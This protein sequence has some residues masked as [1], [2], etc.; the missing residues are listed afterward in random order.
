MDERL[1]KIL[2]MVEK[3][4]RYTG[5]ETNS[6][7]KDLNKVSLKVALAFPDIY[8]IGISNLG[9]QILYHVLNS[10]DD[11]A[12]ER[13]YSVWGDMEEKM[14]QEGI[15][16]CSLESALPLSDFDIIGV[17]LQHELAYT[18]MLNMLDLGGVPL[19]ASERGDND[20]L[21]LA[22]G[23]SSF[24]PET[25]S[26]FIDAF[27]IG[28]GEDGL[29]EI[30]DT[31]IKWKEKGPEKGTG[32]RDLLLDLSKIKG[33]YIPSLFSF[34]FADTG[35]I[36]KINSIEKEYKGVER[37]LVP[38]L[39]SAP[40]PTSFIVPNVRP[41]HDR[42]SLEVA[43]GCSRFCHF[44]QA[45]Y[46][47][48]PV[49]ERS[50]EKIREIGE[51]AL[52]ETGFDEAALLS[53]STGD[54][55]CL[56]GLLPDL[57]SRYK[58]KNVNLSFPS[59]RVDTITP[60]IMG[61][62]KKMRANSFTI[63]PEAGTQRMRDLI[64]KGV[65]EEQILDTVTEMSKAG[66]KSVKLYFMIGLPTETMEDL[67]GIIDLSRAILKTGRSTGTM[68]QVT[69][70]I[71]AFVP[72]AHTPFQ[73]AEQDSAEKTAEKH[74]YLRSTLRDRGISLKWQDP[75]M[76]VLEGA[77]SRG[78][79]RVGKAILGAFKKGCRFDSWNDQL[80]RSH[81]EEAFAE[82]GIEMSDYL[83]RRAHDETL[84]WDLVNTGVDKSFLFD[85]LKRSDLGA[86]TE[87]CRYGKCS[88]CGVC[89]HKTVKINLFKGDVLSPLAEPKVATSPLKTR[90]RVNYSKEGPARFLGH[91]DCMEGLVRALRRSG[92]PLIYSSG[93]HPSPKIS[94]GSPIPLGTESNAEYF[95]IEIEGNIS[96]EDFMES[97]RAKAPAICAIKDAFVIP[98]KSLSITNSV[99]TEVYI[100]KAD[101]TLIPAETMDEVLAKFIEAKE[102]IIVKRTKKGE[103]KIDLK[104]E[105]TNL[106]V[107]S[108][109]DIE[110]D[111]AALGGRKVKP[112]EAIAGI[113]NLD[114]TQKKDLDIMKSETIFK[115][116]LA[117]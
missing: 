14:R 100:F 75:F 78:D 65:T 69:V 39:D 44:C 9:L 5:G 2:P 46:I 40:Y 68:R 13:V 8:E 102:W 96:A 62:M 116:G 58:K 111:I 43:R 12:A 97:L 76:S 89:D 28:D 22:G 107:N 10:R 15:P 87:D 82:A 101:P 84:P 55:S 77:F 47:Y 79:R 56:E 57:A 88:V 74:S 51:C 81:W 90:M 26:D 29:V 54:Y 80:N 106:K 63:A 7:K 117:D 6:I 113:W 27:L 94:F 16:L 1:R 93:F 52:G 73:W 71:S 70:G 50:P 86:L 91:I 21:V 41:V 83:R 114:E 19:L 92:L 72:K 59:L 4:G 109:G 30:C 33:V 105:L 45:G 98:L 103:K 99:E 23:P 67:D 108:S 11:I 17:S 42:I 37:R 61:E 38:D 34:A 53:L 24:N 35:R 64:N 66:C 18:N 110:M 31:Y 115:A 48:L 3:P 20:P 25:A 49:R 95:D 60:S 104:K 32:R 36:E 85:E 112:A